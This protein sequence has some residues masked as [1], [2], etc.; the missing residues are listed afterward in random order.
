M[1][2]FLAT[3]SAQVVLYV[4]ALLVMLVVAFYVVQRLRDFDDEDTVSA[5]DLMTNFQE[6]HEE[7]DINGME[8]RTIK[9]VLN[10]Q[11]KDELNER[12]EQG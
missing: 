12:E 1:F 11:L 2:D 8:Y 3:P 9:T 10:D 4:A 6:M 7:G 5:S